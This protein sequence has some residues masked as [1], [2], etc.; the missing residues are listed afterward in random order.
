MK[1]ITEE[2]LEQKLKTLAGEAKPN[3]NFEKALL[4]KVK[5]QFKA[6]HNHSFW[7]NFSNFKVQFAGTVAI[8]ALAITTNYAYQNDSVVPGKI[9]YPVKRGAEKVEAIFIPE[10]LPKSDYYL[11]MAERRTEEL[12]YIKEDAK[13]EETANETRKLLDLAKEELAETEP[14]E[15]YNNGSTSAPAMM[16]EMDSEASL[17][18]SADEDDYADEADYA[19]ED[20][21]SSSGTEESD[22][23]I[24]DEA[25]LQDRIQ[26]AESDLEKA[27]AAHKEENTTNSPTTDSPAPA[28]Q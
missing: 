12:K 11:D 20:D 26:N 6:T 4:T 21:E 15:T 5:S 13:F 19:E 27:E 17:A 8:L 28:A 14:A 10:G 1:K 22:S 16:M 23:D 9:L 7:Q 24:S 2:K 3:K 25:T 18:D